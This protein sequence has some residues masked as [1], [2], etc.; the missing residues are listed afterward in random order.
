MKIQ[1]LSVCVP[2]PNGKCVNDCRFCV[3]HMRN[4]NYPVNNDEEAL[5]DR[6]GFAFKNG[7]NTVVYTGQCEPIQNK[8]FMKM[9][10]RNI[11]Y[12][13]PYGII[14]EI[15]TTGVILDDNNLKFLKDIGINTISLS[16]S[17][18]SDPVNENI[19]RPVSEVIYYPI[20]ELCQR[21]EDKNF[22]LRLSLNMT[23]A[24]DI[25]PEGLFD[26]CKV[27]GANQVT[28]R[29]MY[30]D[31]GS[32]EQSEYVKNFC[33]KEKDL[34][35]FYDFIMARGKPL[36]RLPFGAIKYSYNEMGIVVDMSC[37]HQDG[38]SLDRETELY[39]YLILR[40]NMKLYSRWD[41]KGSLVF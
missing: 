2:S 33:L 29:L 24:M 16:V 38:P 20:R 7:C 23:D 25:S 12:M 19:I 17:S 11:A 21:I 34:Y 37:M 36:E 28:L 39:R 13:R 5:R 10:S 9:V 40:P 1:S 32:N 22:N 3:S 35:K 18:F 6:L 41:D 31:D 30:N 26:I 4:D 8:D 14:Q 15:Q 27:Y